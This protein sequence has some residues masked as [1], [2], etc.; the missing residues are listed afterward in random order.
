MEGER[1]QIEQ[2]LREELQFHFDRVY[3]ELLAAGLT[4]EEAR[5]AAQKRFG[6]FT[7][8]QAKVLA[9]YRSNG[10][11]N[12]RTGL[13]EPLLYSLRFAW[14][15]ALRR[16][17]FGL[18]VILML[19]LGVGVNAMIFGVVDRLLL[20]PPLHIRDAER[21]RLFY[22]DRK[23]GEERFV[24]TYF[25]F[26]DYLHFKKARSFREL[27]AVAW[28]QLTLG[29][30]PGGQTVWTQLV[31][32]SFF[33]M[34]GVRP[35]LGRFFEEREDVAG[36]VPT[37][38][39]SHHLWKERFGGD[40]SIL[41][42]SVSIGR[43]SY[44][45]VGIAPPG[46]TGVDI[47][48][49]DLWLPL[50]ITA[51]SRYG[52]VWR[53]NFNYWWI[54]IAGR[55]AAGVSPEAASAEVTGLHRQISAQMRE[56]E[57]DPQATVQAASLIAADGPDAP[58]E[59]R[60]ARWLAAVALIVLLIACF[61]VANLLLARTVGRRQEIAVRFALGCNRI[62]ILWSLLSESF[63][64]SLMG[65]G[66]AVGVA[67]LGSR[68]IQEYLLPNYDW[69]SGGISPR[70]LLFTLGLGA[71]AGCLVGALPALQ[72]AALGTSGFRTTYTSSRRR[73]RGSSLLLFLQAAL[74]VLL[75]IGAGLFVLSFQRA[76][77][78]DLGFEPSGVRVL[79]PIWESSESPGPVN[80]RFLGMMKEIRSFPGV[81][82]V[83]AT[84]SIPFRDSW[85][86]RLRLPGR[87][88]ERTAGEGP[89][90]YAVAGDFFQTLGLEILRGR[91]FSESDNEKGEKVAVVSRKMAETLW[92]GEEALG[93]CLL[94]GDAEQPPCTRVVGVVENA[95]RQALLESPNLLL[96]LPAT[97]FQER[98][99]SSIY[100][101]A[102][103]NQ[104]L[105][106]LEREIYQNIPGLRH[107]RQA[108][109]SDFIAPHKRAWRL[110]AIIFSVF[111]LLALLV[112]AFGL[113]SSLTFEVNLRLR[114]LGIRSA[115]GAQ[116]SDLVKLIL[117]QA[118]Y[119]VVP[120]ILLGTLLSVLLSSRISD[121]LFQ[122]SPLDPKVFLTVFATVLLTT[123][124][125]ALI[126]G[127]RAGRIDPNKVL[128]NGV[129]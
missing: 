105:T 7:S 41:G 23:F 35:Q 44:Q 87:E 93:Q 80:R 45:I 6:D 56:Q 128:R 69:S 119:W 117:R 52:N 97:Q 34:L 74:S 49:V 109:L 9:L 53:D 21:V 60:V 33:S 37:V 127:L 122:I 40:S 83:A 54:F 50:E 75:L 123:F 94:V 79:T 86:T 18:A 36:A 22:L 8:H 67:A 114:E 68:L 58:G 19:A 65:A 129:N 30:G 10:A 102:L 28:D 111:G 90:F 78:I 39:L 110:G 126:P 88:F 82:A 14:R 120:G 99:L 38:V 73:S 48:R 112:A 15:G 81:E 89:Y 20:R 63:L 96:Y 124:L 29:R 25:T 27:A 62:R 26:P 76:N 51:E 17:G 66:A 61:N 103:Q 107:L 4:P 43:L 71:I 11:G 72:A 70:N 46:F 118:L 47:R 106:G 116:V 100:V 42:T 108:S 104:P 91:S 5:E 121:L 31:T 98:P 101:R 3:E 2:E 92:P 57:Y 85:S 115:L 113:Y 32:P 84:S 59:A 12:W 13:L 24:S 64:L 16:P 55:L 1:R 77:G 95:R 125:A